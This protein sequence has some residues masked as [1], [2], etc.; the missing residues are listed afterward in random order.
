[1]T[2]SEFLLA[3][4]AEDEEVARTASG[5]TVIGEPYNWRP[6]DTGDEWAPNVDL[7]NGDVEVLVAL[8]PGLP[9][10]ANVM[11]GYWG[12]VVSLAEGAGA[13]EN[14]SPES[15]LAAHIARHDPARVLAECEAKRRIVEMHAYQE[16]HFTPDELRALALPYADHP[17]YREEWRP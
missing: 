9:R 16:E 14:L 1:M 12:Q 2:L 15:D 8:R 10:P 7:R 11:S 13:N 17:D 3:R 6:V 5:G 4:I